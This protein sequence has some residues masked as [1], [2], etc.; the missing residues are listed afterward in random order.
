MYFYRWLLLPLSR[1]KCNWFSGQKVKVQGQSRPRHNCRRQ[2]V[3]FLFV[4]FMWLQRSYKT[5]KHE[6]WHAIWPW[7]LILKENFLKRP[8]ADSTVSKLPGSRLALPW[9]FWLTSC[10]TEALPVCPWLNCMPQLVLRT[11]LTSCYV[12]CVFI[13]DCRCLFVSRM[14]WS[15]WGDNAKIERANLDG[16]ARTVLVNTSLAWPNGLTID[17]DERRVYWGDAKLDRIETC[18]LDGSDR[19]VVVS[20]DLPHIFGLTLL[21]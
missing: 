19:R 4:F 18:R 13:V 5:P 1:S 6:T 3:K 17:Y 2:P 20:S 11:A 21:G 9:A 8:A 15:D 7:C 16:S 14:Y 10:S 12:A